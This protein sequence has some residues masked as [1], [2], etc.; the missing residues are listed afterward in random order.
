VELAKAALND[1]PH[2]RKAKGA[3]LAA[4]VSCNPLLYRTLIVPLS[5]AI[6]MDLNV[7]HAAHDA[8]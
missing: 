8:L 6:T 3:H 2:E 1:C 4:F 7:A 5:R